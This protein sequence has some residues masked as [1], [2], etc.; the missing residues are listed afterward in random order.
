MW[1]GLRSPSQRAACAAVQPRWSKSG[2]VTAKQA[3][4]GN[5]LFQFLPRG[6]RFGHH[7]AHRDDRGFGSRARLAQPIAAGERGFA[8][9]VVVALDL[10][11]FA[12]RQP[13]IGAFA[14]RIVDQPEGFLHHRRELVGKG[15][16]V[17]AQARLAERDQRRVDRLVRAAFGTE[18]DP[19]RGRDQ[20]EARVLVASV[21]EAIEAARDERVVERSDREQARAEQVA[22]ETRRGEHQEQIA[23]GDAELDVLALLGRAPFLRR[24]DFRLGEYVGDLLA[25]EQ[26]ALVHPGAEVGRDGDVGRSGDDAVGEVAAGFRQVEQDPAERGLR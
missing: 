12:G 13:Q 6:E 19:A 8:P 2:D 9:A 11:D 18:R 21:I 22:G 7:R 4:A 10:R 5:V 20:Q 14:G 16:L 25:V 26:A 3:E 15:R 1:L 17:M 23:L 24:R